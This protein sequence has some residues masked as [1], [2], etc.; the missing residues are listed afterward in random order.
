[1]PQ[2]RDL[3]FVEKIYVTR[4]SAHGSCVYTDARVRRSFGMAAVFIFNTF[5]PNL[6]RATFAV[7][8]L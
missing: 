5:S 6:S 2:P 1:M 7:I 3:F 4:D 8:N